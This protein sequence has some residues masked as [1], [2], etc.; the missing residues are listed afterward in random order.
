LTPE[1]LSRLPGIGMKLANSIYFDIQNNIK[2][3]PLPKIMAASGVFSGFAE[4]R[5]K[6]IVQAYPDIL[7]YSNDPNLPFILQQLSGFNNLSYKFAEDLPHFIQW[8]YDHPLITVSIPVQS[9][10]NALNNVTVVFS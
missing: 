6:Q 8:L 9:M 10:N 2:D 3:V 5:L 7:Q 1:Q 4:K